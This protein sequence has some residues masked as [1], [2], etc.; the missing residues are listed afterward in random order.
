[1]ALPLQIELDAVSKRFGRTHALREL[2]L[3]VEPGEGLRPDRSE[4]LR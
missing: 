2:S 1:M 4:R 3:G